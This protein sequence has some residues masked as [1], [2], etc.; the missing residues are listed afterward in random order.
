MSA[1]ASGIGTSTAG[2]VVKVSGNNNQVTVASKGVSYSK[3]S[4][5]AAAT[6]GGTF[7]SGGKPT[8]P[9]GGGTGGGSGTGGGGTSGGSG[10]NTTENTDKPQFSYDIFGYVEL[11]LQYFADKTKSIADRINDYINKTLKKT[12]LGKQIEAIQTEIKANSRAASTYTDFAEKLA[13]AYSY[14]DKDGNKATVN[15]WSKFNRDD[16]LQGKYQLD[17]IETT[18]PADAAM[19]EGA[20]AYLDYINKARE[21][22]SAIQELTNTMRELQDQIIQIPTE[23]LE[24]TLEIIENRIKTISGVSSAMSSGLSGIA[25]IKRAV[26]QATGIDV[27]KENKNK[28][29]SAAQ[30]VADKSTKDLANKQ[31]NYDKWSANAVEKKSKADE[32]IKKLRYYN[33]NSSATSAQKDAIRKAINSGKTISDQEMEKLGIHGV[34]L[35]GLKYYIKQYNNAINARNDANKNEATSK[36]LLDNAKTQ[37]K[38]DLKAVENAK[39]AGNKV[40]N[41][42]KNR[43]TPQMGVVMNASR[44]DPTYITQNKYLDEELRQMRM[45]LNKRLEAQK[46]QENTTANFQKN[47]NTHKA[48]VDKIKNDNNYKKASAS[49]K[50]I[51]DNAIKYG[52]KIDPTK[53]TSISAAVISEWNNSILSLGNATTA[54]Q[55]AKEQEQKMKEELMQS[56]LEVAEREQKAAEEKMENITNWYK[57]AIDYAKTQADSFSKMR[58][59]WKERGYYISMDNLNNSSEQMDRHKTSLYD[60]ITYF[61]RQFAKKP[62]KDG[63]QGPVASVKAGSVVNKLY[64]NYNAQIG[65]LQKMQEDYK[66]MVEKQTEQLEDMLAKGTILSG[67]EEHKKMLADIEEAKTEVLDLDSEIQKLYDSMREDVYFK[68]IEYTIKQMDTLRKATDQLKGLISQEMIYTTDGTFTN[69]GTVK[70]TMDVQ[71]YKQAQDQL[72]QIIQEQQVINERFTLDSSFSMEEYMEKMQALEAQYRDTMGNLVSYRQAIIKDVTDRYQTE[73]TYINKLIDAK[74]NELNKRK[75]LYDYDKKLRKQNKDV[76]LIEQQIRAL[77]GLII[78]GI[79][80]NCWEPLR[81]LLLQ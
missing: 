78:L 56:A 4:N 53:I 54:L 62:N 17:Q 2:N 13:Q 70:Y 57:T 59:V 71:S 34:K 32:A 37:N 21:A 40:I 60:G 72:T 67:S 30:A 39:K 42:M 66:E 18:N 75:E 51:I 74:K 46:E 52:T 80:F 11:R 48:N 36:R 61:Y 44:K 58:N 41:E 73:I 49:D 55:Q 65:K 3:A 19:V 23:R 24:H 68:P 28:A 63:S 69:L 45:E 25:S 26:E 1:Y 29:V 38:T 5:P 12:L 76:Q 15:I 20:R 10:D 33:N 64:Q 6:V 77:N 50:A 7:T 35:S 47:Y 31:K 9:A 22:N 79:L 43:L 8:N 16:L 27:A 14:T 81:D